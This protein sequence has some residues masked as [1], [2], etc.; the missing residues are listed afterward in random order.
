MMDAAT[1][2]AASIEEAARC[3][4]VKT[5]CP[6]SSVDGDKSAAPVGVTEEE[7]E[8]VNSLGARRCHD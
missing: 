8:L 2:A 1:D 3:A 7:F 4:S 6:K 5:L